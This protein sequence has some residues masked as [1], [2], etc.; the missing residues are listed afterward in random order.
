MLPAFFGE[1]A[2]D[3]QVD[4][5]MAVA[6]GAVRERHDGWMPVLYTRLRTGR[7]FAEPE[8]VPVAASAPIPLFTIPDP[9]VDFVGR[10]EEIEELLEV[11][12]MGE[13]ALRHQGA[14]G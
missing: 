3:G 14:W 6:R 4:R 12:G 5:A 7:I 11:F 1:L 9:P 8:R 2:W 13:Q 10:K